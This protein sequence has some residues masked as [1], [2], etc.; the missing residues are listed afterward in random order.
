MWLTNLLSSK[1]SRAADRVSPLRQ[2]QH[3]SDRFVHKND[4]V[5]QRTVPYSPQQNGVAERMK[6]DSSEEDMHYKVVSTKWWEKAFN[7]VVHWINHSVTTLRSEMTSYASN[8]KIKP[9][10][11]HLQVLGSEGYTYMESTNRTNLELKSFRGCRFLGHVS[12]TKGHRVYYLKASKVKVS[13][14]VKL[15]EREI[16]MI[17]GTHLNQHETVIHRVKC[18]PTSMYT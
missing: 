6:P 15:E 1:L 7:T 8:F 18:R 10:T 9:R 14:L 3:E 5:H 13:Q 12:N 17:G 2:S 4:I 16:S 11:K